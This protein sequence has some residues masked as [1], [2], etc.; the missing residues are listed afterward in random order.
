MRE[1]MDFLYNCTHCIYNIPTNDKTK[2]VD[3]QGGYVASSHS[4]NICGSFS[5]LFAG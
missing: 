3:T 5:K 2:Y 4:G 1:I